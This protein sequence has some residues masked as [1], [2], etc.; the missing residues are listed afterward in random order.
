MVSRISKYRI[1]FILKF[2]QPTRPSRWKH[3]DYS[4]YCYHFTRCN[5]L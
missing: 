4:E 1:I 2:K 5:S 3:C